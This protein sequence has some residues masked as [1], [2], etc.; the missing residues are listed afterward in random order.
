[1]VRFLTIAACVAAL[2]LCATLVA[3]RFTITVT[4]RPVSEPSQAPATISTDPPAA[5]KPVRKVDSHHTK[6]A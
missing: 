3:S 6:G 5:S 2:L 1:M 4:I